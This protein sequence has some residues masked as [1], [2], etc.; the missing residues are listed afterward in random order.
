MK[1]FMLTALVAASLPLTLACTSG[2]PQSAQTSAPPA[3][4]VAT[5]AE[6]VPE[7]ITGLERDW[8]KAIVAKDAAT[9]DRLIDD[10]F[11]GTTNDIE[12]TKSMAIDDVKTGTHDSIDL[13]NIVVHVY[14][15]AAVSTM[16]QTEKSRHG[17]EDFSGHYLFTD[18][19]V[20]RDGQWRAVASHGSRIR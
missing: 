10:D 13:S 18:T 8:V 6:N 1:S 7:V 11:V 14:G 9:V 12:Y 4:T 15:N 2:S 17:S 20:K 16:D 19:W 3:A 5:T